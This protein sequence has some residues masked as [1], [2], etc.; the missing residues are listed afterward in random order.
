MISSKEQ[1]INYFKSGIRETKDYKIGIEH[2]KFLFDQNKNKRVDY[3][4]ILKMFK[5]L[6]EF[7][8]KP[9]L[10]NKNIIGLKKS[11]KSITLEPGNQIELSGDQ[12]NNI[13]EACSESQDYLFEI[14]QVIKKLN[15]KI[16]SAGFDP[17]S[18]ISEVSNNPKQRY[19]VMTKD[20][21]KGGELSLDMMYRTCGTQ[22]N[23]DYNSEKDFVK[24]FKIVNSIV[25]ISIAL[26]ANSSIVEKKNSNY[27]SYRSKV[28]QNTSRGGLPEAFFDNMDFEKYAGFIMNFPMLFIQKDNEY[29]SGKNYLFTDFMNGKIKE[30][31]NKL[32]TESDLTTHL[33]TIFT[34]NRLK[35]YIELRSMDACGWE[36]LC[37][38]PA[39][40]T[41]ILYGNLDEAYDLISKWDK[42]K[43]INAYLEAPKKGFNTELMG[44]DLFY[45]TSILLEISKKGLESRDIIGRGGYNE[46]HY[47]SHLEKIIDNRIT[48]ADHMIREFSKNENLNDLYD[49]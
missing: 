17:I 40:N 25:P 38:G 6:Y 33:S 9:I 14:K 13:H 3:P 10:E 27:L 12:L 31:E 23:V 29:I 28:W 18:K 16:V 2:E 11:G 49:K 45:W 7:G 48:N 36:C 22:L 39:F 26:F 41:G 15:L 46:T 5:G 24:K 34:E 20:M 42:N 32:P 35:K 8:W 37:S 43:I 4:T 19:E 47:L 30:L 44:K 21:P 1:I